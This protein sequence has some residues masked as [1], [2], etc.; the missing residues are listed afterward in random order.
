MKKKK[1]FRE[2]NWTIRRHENVFHNSTENSL[3]MNIKLEENKKQYKDNY[4]NI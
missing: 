3:E 4:A 1:N 2:N